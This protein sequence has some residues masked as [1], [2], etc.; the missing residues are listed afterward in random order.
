MALQ[1]QSRLADLT[2]HRFRVNLQTITAEVARR[3]EKAPD[4]PGVII[5]G[6]GGTVA[7][8]ISRQLFFRTMS[9]QYAIE[10][11]SRKPIA[12][13]W[14]TIRTPMLV[15]P[16]DCRID[17]AA[18]ALLRRPAEKVSE[19]VLVQFPDE[20]PALLDANVLL[21]AQ[22]Q[23]LA[24]AIETIRQQK[25]SAEQASRHKS[26]FLANVSHEIR[27]PMNGII[28]MTD[29]ALQ[30]DLSEEQREYLQLVKVSAESLLT[31]INDLL[32]FSK[33]EAGK[34]EL[35]PMR[36]DLRSRLGEVMR[37]LAIRAHAKQ[38]Q[39]NL[40]VDPEVPDALEGDP[41]RL[42]QV[43]V[44]LVG[45][46]IK[47]TQRGEVNIHV[48]RAQQQQG[49]GRGS[50]KD[51]SI[52]LHFSITDTGIGIA[53][54]KQRLVFEPF[55]QADGS[56]TRQ[57]G[58]TGLG[59]SISRKLV[60]MMGGEIWVES[61]SGQGS[62][63]HFTSRF[64][65][66]EA[67]Q[68]QGLRLEGN[69]RVLVVDDNL[70]SR[71]ITRQLLESWNLR[72][73]EAD[74]TERALELLESDVSGFDL[75]LFDLGLPRINGLELAGRLQADG[76]FAKVPIVLLS[77]TGHPLERARC[78]EM[79]IEHYLLKPVLEDALLR[80]VRTAL[81]GGTA[82]VAETRP[83]DKEQSLSGTPLRLLLAED[84]RVNQ[85]L[86]V[87]MLE[88]HGH[89]LTICEDGLEALQAIESQP[90]DLVLMDIQMP[91]MDGL[92]A[93][94]ELRRR[95]SGT[96]RRLPVIAMTAHAIRGDKERC[97]AGGMDGYVA[98]PLRIDALLSEIDR[99]MG[100]RRTEAS[101]PVAPIASQTIATSRTV[102]LDER[103]L[104]RQLDD[105]NLLRGVIGVFLDEAPAQLRA[106]GEAAAASDAQ[107]LHRSA[108]RFRGSLGVFGE[109]PAYEK[110]RRLDE[111]ALAGK[112]ADASALLGP[113]NEAVEELTH[114]LKLVSTRS[115][116]EN[117]DR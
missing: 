10:L 28:G 92:E 68:R 90:F 103:A 115:H 1:W 22:T 31:V 33:I 62:T 39:L 110:I 86:A 72:V 8:T 19:P 96:G 6:A 59:L 17:E 56:T 29:L 27:T 52:E 70:T 116:H 13:L 93:V 44:N 105:E 78:R 26:E 64:R 80:V 14:E 42:R 87:A 106:I 108:H 45:N 117:S 82:H 101:Q 51:G 20:P 2:L 109:T 75:F 77:A 69:Q 54:E 84:N 12:A 98:K 38:L 47:F 48:A 66:G 104:R 67:S 4:L 37:T 23:V 32:D 112:L 21:R 41:D 34:L 65:S 3:L 53:K 24:Q 94:R 9:H 79:H 114:D 73:S 7:G 95:E 100:P 76:R 102:V 71:R 35:S 40:L 99:V 11:F 74:S 43:I 46:S 111:L 97:L 85:K 83:A 25:E 63:F 113:L 18:A 107:A 89:Q 49:G 30:T 60:E 91:N 58:G 36:F 61:Q 50:A 16:A 57:Y 88:K 55:I 15:L 5:E 81:L